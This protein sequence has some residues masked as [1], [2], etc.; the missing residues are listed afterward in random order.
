MARLLEREL[1]NRVVLELGG[2]WTRLVV[3]ST[4]R[5]V[6]TNTCR[7][8]ATV[9]PDE[10]LAWVMKQLS[11][12]RPEL[13]DG[14]AIASFGPVDLDSGIV[15]PHCP[16]QRW[17][18]FNFRQAF[19]NLLPGVMVSLT[20]DTQ[21][22]ALGEASQ[23]SGIGQSLIAY[24]TVGTGVGLGLATNQYGIL[25]SSGHPEFGHIH[26][27]RRQSDNFDGICEYHGDCLE[28]LI[29]GPA[30]SRRTGI[31]PSTKL[32]DSHQVWSDVSSE[33]G[34]AMATLALTVAPDCIILGGGVSDR[35]FLL[36]DVRASMDRHLGGYLDEAG[37]PPSSER[38][39]PPS[40]GGKAAL[41][42][43]FLNLEK[44]S[45]K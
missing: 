16:K 41:I 27:A 45:R 10:T 35:P 15:S 39:V 14:I 13:I 1:R 34:S 38:L 17:R 2:T 23:G 6:T 8:T 18:G 3:A 24:V 22:S 42:G 26:V 40:L 5:E 37:H 44:L 36:E 30:L 21:A 12:E 20:T 4:L 32:L 43:A 25:P 33:L 28:G 19:S 9:S 11:D 31:E 7:V 29:S